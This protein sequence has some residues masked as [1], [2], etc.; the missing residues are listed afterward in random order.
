MLEGKQLEQLLDIISSTDQ[1]LEDIESNFLSLFADS[2][3]V[4]NA[5]LT[6]SN[7][8]NHNV[9]PLSPSSSPIPSASAPSSSSSKTSSRKVSSA[10]PSEPPS[11]RPHKVPPNPSSAK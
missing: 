4:F 6:I 8:L 9:A 5:S 2:F 3:P 1:S 10:T 11:S 7:L